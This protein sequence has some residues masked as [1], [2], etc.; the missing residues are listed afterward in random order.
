MTEKEQESAP[1]PVLQAAI[2]LPTPTPCLKQH[3]ALTRAVQLTLNFSAKSNSSSL[4][5]T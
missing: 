4:S 3:K 1:S 5:V 2:S